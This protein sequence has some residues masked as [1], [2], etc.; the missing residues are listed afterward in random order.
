MTPFELRVYTAEEPKVEMILE[1]NHRVFI[2]GLG[3]SVLPDH[4]FLFVFR[5]GKNPISKFFVVFLAMSMRAT[6]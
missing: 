5:S 1:V 4:S 6:P 3:L 2:T